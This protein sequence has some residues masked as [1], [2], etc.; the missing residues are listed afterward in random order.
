MESFSAKWSTNVST[1]FVHHHN[2]KERL[3]F[4]NVRQVHEELSIGRVPNDLIQDTRVEV[5]HKNMASSY[6]RRKCQSPEKR[7]P[8]EGIPEEG[9]PEEGIPE[10][11]IP[12]DGIP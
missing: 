10:D 11:G 8:E 2:R 4:Q 7:I 3:T 5:F 6:K 9:I 12:E 1:V